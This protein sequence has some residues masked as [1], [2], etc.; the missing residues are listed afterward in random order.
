MTIEHI[1]AFHRVVGVTV[2]PP[3]TVQLMF[4]DGMVRRIDL[5][6]ELHGEVFE[7]LKDPAFFAQ[8]HVE[9]GTIA[10][11]NGADLA[12]EFLYEAGEVMSPP[13]H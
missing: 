3:Y 10:W 11:P 6:P 9:G 5:E 4:D 2:L 8:V 12:P 7:P 1:T 13:A